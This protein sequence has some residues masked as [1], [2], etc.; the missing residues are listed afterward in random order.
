MTMRCKA[1]QISSSDPGSSLQGCA[2][3]VGLHKAVIALPVCVSGDVTIQSARFSSARL[4]C[5]CSPSNQ[6]FQALI[7]TKPTA[8]SPLY[9]NRSPFAVHQE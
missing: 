8:F 2:P 5:T 4:F 1:H 3:C 9:I 6:M 7:C